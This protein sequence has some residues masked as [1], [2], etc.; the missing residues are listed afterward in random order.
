[1]KQSKVLDK[2]RRK[3]NIIN[4]IIYVLMFVALYVHLTSTSVETV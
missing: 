2:E 3:S 4:V 1:M